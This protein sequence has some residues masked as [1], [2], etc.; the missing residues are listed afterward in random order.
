MTCHNTINKLKDIK[1]RAVICVYGEEKDI[2]YYLAN[3]K[4]NL[5]NEDTIESVWATSRENILNYLEEKQDFL[6]TNY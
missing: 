5:S 4:Y 1:D 3:V 2:L 6:Y